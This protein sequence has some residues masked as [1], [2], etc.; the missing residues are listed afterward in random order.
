MLS[1]ILILDKPLRMSSAQ[2]VA[3]VKRRIGDRRTK[4]G[5]AG[6]LDPLATGVLVIAIG[7]ATK[8]ID[9]LMATSKRYR[10]VID[11]S[12]F[13]TTDDAEGERSEVACQ[14]PP[15]RE[16]I[17]AVLATRFHGTIMQKPPAYSA[18]KVGGRRAYAIARG[19]AEPEV[20]PRP[21]V[22]HS[23]SVVDYRWPILEL[24]IHCG[25][26]FYVRSLARELGEA[27]N[28]GGHCASIRRT[29]VGPFTIDGAV[30]MDDLPAALTGD[31]LISI[32]DALRRVQDTAG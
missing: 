28:T 30:A 9:R 11:L 8:S 16:R 26:G 21:V 19:G 10:T 29:A 25:K 4:V 17:D 27:L 31:H 3:A 32:E 2:A 20:A 18:V 7:A 5:H 24:N 23:I 15:T 13:S 14:A 1:G 12:A 6:T 22:A